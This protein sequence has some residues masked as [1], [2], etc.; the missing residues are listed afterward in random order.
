MNECGS[1]TVSLDMELY[2]GMRDA[3]NLDSYSENISNVHAVIPQILDLF[4]K[5]QIHATWAIVGFLFF[6]NKEEL[7]Q[8]LPSKF[9]SYI[10]KVYSPYDYIQKNE[11][12]EKYHFA[13]K[14]ISLI[15]HAPFQEIGTHTYSHYFALE[16]GQ[17]NFEFKNDIEYAIKAQAQIES[18]CKSIVFPRNQYND[19]HLSVLS[20]LGICFYRAMRRDG[21][22]SQG[23]TKQK[24]SS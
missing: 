7:L 11:L 18:Q 24:L 13:P 22:I 6:K 20:S 17:T 19:E 14:S 8:H 10:K 2:W 12:E 9:P 23:I 16:K 3:Q 15:K 5:Y 4:E 1:F 21:Y